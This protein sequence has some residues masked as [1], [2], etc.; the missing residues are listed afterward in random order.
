MT[1]ADSTGPACHHGQQTDCATGVVAGED[2]ISI[3]PLK[4]ASARNCLRHLYL[5]T[6][7][8]EGNASTRS[9]IHEIR[10]PSSDLSRTARDSPPCEWD[11]LPLR[12]FD[13]AH[14]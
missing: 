6:C 2:F 7:G 11:G 4:R 1:R 10:M 13:R 12:L 14:S 5:E 3:A 8:R 9:P